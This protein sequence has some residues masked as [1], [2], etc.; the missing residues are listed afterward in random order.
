MATKL[1]EHFTLEIVFLRIKEFTVV[2]QS[3][4][5]HIKL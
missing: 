3:L 5:S 4:D 2:F 1:T